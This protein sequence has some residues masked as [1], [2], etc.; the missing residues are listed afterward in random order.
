MYRR[1]LPMQR[2]IQFVS[3]ELCILDVQHSTPGK[4]SRPVRVMYWPRIR[5][6]RSISTATFK[7]IWRAVRRLWIRAALYYGGSASQTTPRPGGGRNDSKARYRQHYTRPRRLLPNG[8][9]HR[10]RR[11]LNGAAKSR[12][13]AWRRLHA[14]RRGGPCGRGRRVKGS[15]LTGIQC[16]MCIQLNR[17]G[18][19]LDGMGLGWR[20]RCVVVYEYEA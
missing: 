19:E 1:T 16:S 2:P 9:D 6:V 14:S 7:F 13:M 8:S 4:E 3:T 18:A 17:M 5:Q 20:G 15:G 10:F 11:T 12:L